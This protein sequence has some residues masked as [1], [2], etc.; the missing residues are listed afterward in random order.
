MKIMI[1]LPTALLLVLTACEEGNKRI[2]ADTDTASDGDTLLEDENSDQSEGADSTVT[3]ADFTATC[4]DSIV[5][6]G[7]I[8]DGGLKNCVEIDP[9]SYTGGKAKCLDN[10]TGYDTDTCEE[11]PHTCGND[12]TE[13]P[14]AC[15]GD[16]KN[17]TDIDAELY[18]GGKAKCLADCS[19]YDTATCETV[20]PHEC[21][22]GIVE[23]PEACDG[24]LINCVDIDPQLY[25]GGKAYCEADCTAW[26]IETCDA[27]PTSIDWTAGSVRAADYGARSSHV[28]LVHN[29]YVWVIGGNGKDGMGNDV[30]YNDVWRTNTMS[31]WEQVGAAP[32]TVRARHAGAVFKNKLWVVGGGQSA[33]YYADVWSSADGSVWTQS[34]VSD[35]NFRPGIQAQLA[36][37][38]NELW[39]LTG[40]SD[41]FS[42]VNELWHTA[43]GAAWTKVATPP[44]VGGL[45]GASMTAF[46]GKLIIAG[47][48]NLG[49][50]AVDTVW[51]SSNGADWSSVAGGFTARGF[52]R[53]VV[54]GATMYLTGGN[55]IS[56]R[57]NDV[58]KTQNGTDWELV[59][60]DAGFA[61]VSSHQ[62][63]SFNGEVCVLGGIDVSGVLSSQVWCVAQ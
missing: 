59:E 61:P 31:T 35:T 43:D 5:N 37:L 39:C 8:C 55:L 54:V 14:E 60:A 40:Q 42:I 4:G 3:D 57:E 11:V 28:A 62:V 2:I 53:N 45:I 15:D 22:N 48:I 24:G 51:Y 30:Y 26:D 33:N 34:T 56:T 20:E 50:V 25:S 47:G 7:E 29:G 10:C 49:N 46:S 27:A 23:G 17:C 1:I 19:G 44:A 52:Q 13:G 41:A 21:G 38:N 18:G 32:F 9:L 58:W 36:V 12:I 6:G 16:L 63:V